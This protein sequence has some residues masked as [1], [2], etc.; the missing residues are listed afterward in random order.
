MRFTHVE[1]AQSQVAEALQDKNVASE[2]GKRAC[3]LLAITNELYVPNIKNGVI[4]LPKEYQDSD[5][6]PVAGILPGETLIVDSTAAGFTPQQANNMR[7]H[8]D[9]LHVDHPTFL[10]EDMDRAMV[11][12]VSGAQGRKVN[13]PEESDLGGFGSFSFG[14][15]PSPALRLRFT[16]RVMVF[17]GMRDNYSVV[18]NP[19]ILAHELTHVKQHTQYPFLPFEREP[20]L[21]RRLKD[22]LGA[23][24]AGRA[25]GCY[26]PTPDSSSPLL[27][28]S[29][30]VD[31]LRLKNTEST[32]PYEINNLMAKFLLIALTGAKN[33]LVNDVYPE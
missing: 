5:R 24:Q 26:F 4:S 10:V 19:T 8:L 15:I 18:D 23:Y 33:G 21:E 9:A 13:L 25:V 12:A 14:D 20:L 1:K 6:T 27:N 30:N 16:G 22:E 31:N 29:I 28:N 2:L 32:A 17:L 3:D 7:G 11:S